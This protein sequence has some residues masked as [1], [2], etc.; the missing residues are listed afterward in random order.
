M[1]NAWLLSTWTGTSFACDRKLRSRVGN[2]MRV[3]AELCWAFLLAW[4]A[5][6]PPDW[7][8]PL[9][10]QAKRRWKKKKEK[11]LNE[12]ERWGVKRGKSRTSSY[13]PLSRRCDLRWKKLTFTARGGNYILRPD[14]RLND[15]EIS[16]VYRLS[17]EFRLAKVATL[18]H[19]RR[20]SCR[21]WRSACRATRCTDLDWWRVR[22]PRWLQARK[23]YAESW[24]S[25]DGRS[26]KVLS[27]AGENKSKLLGKQ[28]SRRSAELHGDGR[29]VF[30]YLNLNTQRASWRLTRCDSE[31]K[32]FTI[33]WRE[34]L[35][36]SLAA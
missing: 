23:L 36:A 24:D 11:S 16:W 9:S 1:E 18:P 29:K 15:R 3:A 8:M 32:N 27:L 6:N 22:R 33:I 4:H 35:C 17:A 28:T 12:I 19:I 10:V 20:K 5:S 30:C 21:R 25:L 13:S 26:R 7:A 34:V 31:R 2:Q 14:K